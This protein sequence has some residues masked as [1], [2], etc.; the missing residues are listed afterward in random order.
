LTLFTTPS[1]IALNVP[2]AARS[3]AVTFGPLGLAL[4]ADLERRRAGER[5][6][7]DGVADVAV[8]G[9]L[10]GLG[11]PGRDEAQDRQ[12]LLVG[13]RGVGGGE[14]A[15]GDQGG[16]APVRLDGLPGVVVSWFPPTGSGA[17]IV[18]ASRRKCAQ[19]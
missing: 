9:P 6:Q 2:S 7:A 3:V 14:A 4:G 15:D 19:L 1:G 18:G 10:H 11:R 5:V 12:R 17:P 16:R 8:L 13:Q